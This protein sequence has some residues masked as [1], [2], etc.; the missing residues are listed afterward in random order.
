M[1]RGRGAAAKL[2]SRHEEGGA[3]ATLTSRN[4]CVCL[5]MRVSRIQA[6]S[7]ATVFAGGAI[8]ALS[9]SVTK[10]LLLS[11]SIC[12]EAASICT[13]AN[14]LCSGPKL[15]QHPSSMA[16]V[17][18]EKRG[19]K[20]FLNIT[21]APVTFCGGIMSRLSR[22]CHIRLV[23]CSIATAICGYYIVTITFVWSFAHDRH[24]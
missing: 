23:F 14:E 4:S 19:L 24:L 7:G 12:T 1:E 18:V 21:D 13:G 16:R 6:L 22:N 17:T 8:V 15:P 20:S 9:S 3:E 10:L 11:S 5:F 2:P